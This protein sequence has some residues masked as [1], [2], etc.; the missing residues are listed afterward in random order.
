MAAYNK[1]NAGTCQSSMIEI[2]ALKPDA[3]GVKRIMAEAR[4][5]ERDGSTEYMAKPTE[6]DLFVCIAFGIIQGPVSESNAH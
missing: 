3:S 6:E 1:N 5:L 4:E 2:V